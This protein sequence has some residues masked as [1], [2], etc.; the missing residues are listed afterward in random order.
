MEGGERENIPRVARPPTLT[1]PKRA[2]GSENVVMFGVISRITIT[3]EGFGG[4][5]AGMFVVVQVFC[6]CPCCNIALLLCNW[7]DMEVI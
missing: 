3:S 7:D 4:L 2:N 5:R 1:T 6:R